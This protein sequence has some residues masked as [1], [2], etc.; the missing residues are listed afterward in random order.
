MEGYGTLQPQSA[1]DQERFL[2]RRHDQARAFLATRPIL[3]QE[4][5]CKGLEFR[6]WGSK[7]PR[8]LKSFN[9]PKAEC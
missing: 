9:F 3:G 8:E 6:V 1:T 7:K 4:W 5:E 2:R